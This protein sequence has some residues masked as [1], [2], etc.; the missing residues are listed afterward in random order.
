MDNEIMV[1]N[2]NEETT[3]KEDV[4]GNWACVIGCGSFCILT[5]GSASVI[6][7]V[8]TAL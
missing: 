7:T 2:G 1:L 3:I 4:G 5:G 6:A 8:A